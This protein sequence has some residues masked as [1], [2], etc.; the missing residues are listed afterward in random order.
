MTKEVRIEH[1]SI[2]EMAVPKD[3]YY[4][5][6]SL[7]AKENF[8]MTGQKIHPFMIYYLAAVKKAAAQANALEGALDSQVAQAITTA[9]EEIMEGHLQE[10]F[11]T[12]AIQ[13]GAGTSANMNANEVIANRAQE[14]LGREKGSYD[15]VHPNDHVNR[16]QSTNDVYPTAGKLAAIA[17]TEKALASLDKLI[18]ALDQKAQDFDSVVK[19]GRTQLQDAVPIRLGQ[20]FQAYSAALKRD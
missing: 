2:G 8:P 18:R 6:Q 15:K 10:A 5:V 7:R 19:M 1:D 12:D 3:A 4:G 17:L 14:L 9:C 20:E 11:I 16:G 13:G